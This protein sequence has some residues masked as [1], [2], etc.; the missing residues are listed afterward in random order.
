VI[1]LILSLEIRFENDV[2]SVRQRARQISALLGFDDMEQTRI[3]TAASEIARNAFQHAGQGKAEFLVEDGVASSNPPSFLVRVTDKGPG[4]PDLEAILEGRYKGPGVGILSARRLVDQS[5][6]ESTPGRGTTVLLGRRFPRAAA[7]AP[8]DLGRIRKQLA[9]RTLQD[10]LEE[11]GQQNLELARTLEELRTRQEEL[12][13]L[14]RE[15]EDTNRGVIALYAELDEKT[16]HLRRADELKSRFLSNMSH[17]LRTPVNSIIALCRLM[18]EPSE[19]KLSPE[20]VRQVSFIQK[21]AQA[22]LEL[23]SDLLDLAKV[24]AGRITIIPAPMEVANLFGALRGM[25]RPLLTSPSVSLVFEEPA[26][27]PPMFTDEGKVSQIL[28]N[29]ISNALK[30]TERGEVRVSAGFRP[31]RQ[32]VAFS[33][34]DTGIGIAPEHQELVFQEFAQLNH[35]L[36]KRVKG[37]GLGLPLA[38]KLAELLGGSIGLDSRPGAGSTFFAELPVACPGAKP[39]PAAPDVQPEPAQPREV[40][41]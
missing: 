11:V 34:A 6:I 12:I 27:I 1:R 35:P 26:G 40:Q 24:E 36:Q 9:Q 31:E 30:F 22:L 4:I 18:L 23:V 10:P 2:V 14:N 8:P 21:N 19:E 16:A 33:V 29:F 13:R 17:E 3:A 41:S 38:R 28:R 32:T 15:L 39:E 37:T 5:R 25:F 20:Q 7:F